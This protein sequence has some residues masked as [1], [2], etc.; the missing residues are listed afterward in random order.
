MGYV[1][2]TATSSQQF[3]DLLKIKQPDVQVTSKALEDARRVIDGMVESGVG[4]LIVEQILPKALDLHVDFEV[5][6]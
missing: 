2:M 5:E 3:G 1:L 4:G 6:E